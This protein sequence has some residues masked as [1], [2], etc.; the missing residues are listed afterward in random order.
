MRP[1]GGGTGGGPPSSGSSGGSHPSPRGPGGGGSGGLPLPGAPGGAGG[2]GGG[3]PGAPGGGPPGGGPPPG[4][5]NFIGYPGHPQGPPGGGPPGGGPPG[6]GAPGTAAAPLQPAGEQWQVNHK[7]PLNSV[8]KWNGLGSSLIDYMIELQELSRLGPMVRDG[9]AQYAP[10]E[11]AGKGLSWWRTLPLAARIHITSSW[12]NLMLAIR[13]HFMTDQWIQDRTAEFNA[14]EFRKGR[15]EETPLEYL[16]RRIRVAYFLFPHLGDTHLFIYEILRAIPSEWRTTLSDQIQ[17]NV[18]ELEFAANNFE[19][20]L[21]SLWELHNQSR[22]TSNSQSTTN[23]SG[24]SGGRFFHRRGARQVEIEE[25]SDDEG[26]QKDPIPFEEGILLEEREPVK[27]AAAADARRA[28][29]DKPDWPK[30][31]T[32]N[33]Y[34]FNRRDDVK[35]K[36]APSRGDCFICTSPYHFARDCPH[37]RKWDALRR[38]N[39]IE[40]DQEDLDISDREYVAMLVSTQS[41][42]SAYDGVTALDE[43]VRSAMFTGAYE[44]SLSAATPSLPRNRNERCRASQERDRADRHKGKQRDSSP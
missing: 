34:S 14:M 10:M 2:G 1:G 28:R 16:Q 31:K 21:I 35:S 39:L 44:L 11:W 5:A 27:E 33:G 20:P 40:V 38:A 15:R 30:G 24:T 43:N 7:I 18:Y 32:V 6:G 36:V 26:E 9:L 13:D 42:G 25:V 29:K 17:A 22:S 8:P 19:K 4:P 23:P 37:Y 41:T 12:D 3:P